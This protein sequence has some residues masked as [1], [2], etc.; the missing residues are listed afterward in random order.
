[1][2]EHLCELEQW[3]DLLALSPLVS[4]IPPEL[5]VVMKAR[6]WSK[7]SLRSL[8]QFRQASFQLVL[9]ARNARTS[10]GHWVLGLTKR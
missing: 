1:M 7:W 2:L 5:I 9:T 6:G 3:S 8:G 4:H 10:G